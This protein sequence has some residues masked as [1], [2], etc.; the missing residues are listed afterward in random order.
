MIRT[1]D[2][3][4]TG[5]QFEGLVGFL[6]LAKTVIEKMSVIANSKG[7]SFIIVQDYFLGF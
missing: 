1:A 4:L 5:A 3:Y 2:S 7:L 6:S